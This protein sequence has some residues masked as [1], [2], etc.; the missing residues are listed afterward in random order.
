MKPAVVV[1]ANTPSPS[2][3]PP[4]V[5]FFPRRDGSHQNEVMAEWWTNSSRASLVI[6]SGD[7]SDATHVRNVTFEGAIDLMNAH[8]VQGLGMTNDAVRS[9]A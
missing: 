9:M 6:P 5:Y 3:P 1:L 7:C 8:M 4:L 2:P